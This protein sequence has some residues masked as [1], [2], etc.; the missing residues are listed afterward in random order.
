MRQIF[1]L[2]VLTLIVNFSFAQF[3]LDSLRQVWEDEG[4]PDSSRLKAIDDLSYNG[5]L[6]D[7]P[8]SAF[9]LARLQHDL[10]V[11]VKDTNFMASAYNTMGSSFLMKGVAL[12]GIK[13]F[14][15]CV[16]LYEAINDYRGMAS[17]LNN[18]GIVYHNIGNLKEAVISYTRALKNYDKDDNVINRAK[19]LQNIGS[20]YAELQDWEEALSRYNLCQQLFT[21]LKDDR[22]LAVVTMNK[23]NVLLL[24]GEFEQAKLVYERSIVLTSNISD[25]VN[26]AQVYSNLAGVHRKLGD[27]KSA[28]EFNIKAL[29]LASRIQNVRTLSIVFSSAA[30]AYI[31]ENRPK[32]LEFAEKAYGFAT[33]AN[34]QVEIRDASELLYEIYKSLGRF[35]DAVRM[36]DIQKAASDSLNSKSNRH[37][38]IRQEYKYEYEKQAAADSL[39]ALT[40]H[41]Q[42][43]AELSIR[44]AIIKADAR[45]QK[46]LYAGLV[47]L[48]LLGGFI[49]NRLRVTRRQKKLIEVQKHEVE[50]QK[51]LVDEKNR[52][53]LD[54]IS[55][56]KRIQKAILP[57]DK[58]FKEN[59]PESFVL[60][61]PK[62]I[63]AGDFYWMEKV[64]DTIFFAAADCTGHGVPGAMVSVIC[65]NG[66]NRSVREFGLTE[67]GQILDKTRMLVIQEFEKSEEE[68]KDGMD[69]AMCA[70]DGMKMHYSGANNPLWIVRNGEVLE[71][72]ADKMPIGKYDSLA[73]FRTHTLELQ[74]GDSIYVFTDGYVDQFGGEKGKKLKAK[75]FKELLLSIQDQPMSL[76]KTSLDESF[77]KWRG[78]LEQIDDVCIIGVC[79]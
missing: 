39:I 54:S 70:L 21:E 13:Y 19:A 12:E 52:E 74:E 78:D 66:L 4:A 33:E 10:A 53:I 43:V 11:K 69:I 58:L 34:D 22:G 67:P 63:V 14:D 3:N 64:R 45:F 38:L 51:E 71:T 36:N 56:A 55:Y 46:I 72:K 47:T 31:L 41:L 15:T 6:Y 23:G 8:D 7:D 26:L 32:A 75:N 1:A 40:E 25:T 29:A 17:T 16:Q 62:D 68:V 35:D 59:L 61:K 24:K 44:D 28:Q 50:L 57:P 20:V 76:Q 18:I 73:P 37:E 60:Y 5:F 27:N 30:E 79:I 42:D 48:L 49:L 77:E 2:L 9:V 65:N